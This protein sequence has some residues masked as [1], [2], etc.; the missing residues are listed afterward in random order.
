MA[1]LRK[2]ANNFVIFFFFSNGIYYALSLYLW[3]NIDARGHI[4]APKI[5]KAGIVPGFQTPGE[6]VRNHA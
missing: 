3:A 4:K 6:I 5:Q 1:K 2:S